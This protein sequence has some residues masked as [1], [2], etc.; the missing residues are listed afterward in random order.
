MSNSA[1]RKGIILAGG[2]GSRLAPITLGVSKQLLPVFNKPMIHYPLSILMLSD[3]KEILIILKEK[4]INAYKNLLGDGKQFGIDIK[5]SIQK[6]PDGLAQS[7]LI[8]EKFIDNSPVALILGDNLYHGSGLV[9]Q[10]KRANTQ[11]KNNTIF[12]YRVNDPERYGTVE[13]NEKGK[14][15]N[16]EEKPK[17]PK[18]RYAITGLYFFDNSVVEKAKKVKPSKR[19]ELEI[20]SILNMYLKEKNL[21]LELLGRGIAWFDTGTFD[22]LHQ[23]GSY[24]RT[25]EKR[26]GLKIGCPE[27]ISWRK[28]WISYEEFLQIGYKLGNDDYLEYI[29]RIKED[30]TQGII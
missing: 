22:A 8:G 7:F 30:K 17:N 2:N 26:Q 10:L 27:E 3:I 15:S 1:L 29:K 14:P 12:A 18:S 9:K 11:T 25:I 16:I 6:T 24:I 23:A 5:Y 19:G 13:F 20:T 4:D 28:G 21:D